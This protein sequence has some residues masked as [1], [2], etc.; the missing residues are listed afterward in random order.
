MTWL[1]NNRKKT[2]IVLDDDL[3]VCRAL[4]TQLEILGFDVL[5]FHSAEGLL[6]SEIPTN[7]ACL[8][9][10]VYLPGLNGAE[11]CR[12]LLSSG[13][14]LPTILMSGRDDEETAEIM[15][16]AKPIATLFKPFDQM[17]LMRAV[18]KATRKRRNLPH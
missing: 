11:L 5:V 2:V 15:R 3:F 4:K 13:S 8:L 7:H 6:N 12:R 9:A 10:D 1:S 18:K 14:R 16:A 17:T